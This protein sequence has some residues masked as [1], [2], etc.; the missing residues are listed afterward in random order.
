MKYKETITLISIEMLQ[1]RYFSRILVNRGKIMN[2]VGSSCNALGKICL[3][4]CVTRGRYQQ[5]GITLLL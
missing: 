1:G 2:G 5:P 3:G 4:N